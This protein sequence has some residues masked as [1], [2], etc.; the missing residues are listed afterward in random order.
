MIR[1]ANMTD[2]S[3]LAAI[4]LST[5]ID[6]YAHLNTP[7]NMELYLEGK[8]TEAS[9]T[10]ELAEEHTL[11]LIDESTEG[12]PLAYAKMR[13]NTEESQDPKA[14]EIERIYAKEE[15]QGK[16][17]GKAMIEACYQ[18]AKEKGYETI[19]L[20]VWEHNPNAIG[21]YQKMGFEAFGTHNFQ[22]GQ[23]AQTDLLMKKSLV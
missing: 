10:K 23:D 16:G 14:I 21:F 19:W 17:L 22:L 7:Q 9:V 1:V 5:F 2:A 8:F 11:F 12:I 18:K 15:A 20:G 4:G 6:T 3:T 13:L